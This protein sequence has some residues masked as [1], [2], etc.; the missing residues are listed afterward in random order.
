MIAGACEVVGMT[1][2]TSTAAHRSVANAVFPIVCK[3]VI[4][5]ACPLVFGVMR[6]GTILFNPPREDKSLI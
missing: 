4:S 6:R 1:D 3:V 5:F 2:Q